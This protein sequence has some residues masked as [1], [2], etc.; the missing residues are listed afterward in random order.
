M[1]NRRPPTVEPD[2]ETALAKMVSALTR[3]MGPDSGA[4]NPYSPEKITERA[5]EILSDLIRRG[6]VVIAEK[7]T[8]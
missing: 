5:E 2:R 6:A 8:V 4:M 3:H 1:K 7:A